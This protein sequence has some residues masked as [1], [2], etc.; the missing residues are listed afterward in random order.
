MRSVLDYECRSNLNAKIL[1]RF[2]ILKVYLWNEDP[3]DYLTSVIV[4]VVL[5]TKLK[6]IYKPKQAQKLT[7]TL[8]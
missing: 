1:N 2:I 7:C 3:L 5:K 4:I 8:I 6:Q